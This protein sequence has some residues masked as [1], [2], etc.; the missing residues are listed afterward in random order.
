MIQVKHDIPAQ[1]A[2][3]YGEYVE[4]LSLKPNDVMWVVL[5]HGHKIMMLSKEQHRAMVEKL[6]T[7]GNEQD[8]IVRCDEYQKMRETKWKWGKKYDDMTL[9]MALGRR[10]ED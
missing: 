9:A 7:S 5:F 8:G 6:L 2:K 4:C 1:Y 3:L 10:D